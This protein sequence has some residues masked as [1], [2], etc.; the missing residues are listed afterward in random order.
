MRKQNKGKQLTAN[1]L[2]SILSTEQYP[3]PGLIPLP[4]HENPN[5][6]A[7]QIVGYFTPVGYGSGDAAQGPNP[8][9]APPPPQLQSHP[10]GHLIP[11]NYDGMY[12]SKTGLAATT[13][14]PLAGGNGRA[15]DASAGQKKRICGVSKSVFILVCIIVGLIVA[16]IIGGSVTGVVL[17]NK[18]NDRY[19]WAIHISGVKYLVKPALSDL[20]PL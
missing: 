6:P 10:I 14:G 16:A 12:E 18:S 17:K 13:G 5:Y 2:Y 1:L 8:I 9:S 19:V 20:S 15:G 4:T 3:S 11:V 7:P